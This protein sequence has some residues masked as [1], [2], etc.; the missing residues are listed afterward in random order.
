MQREQKERMTCIYFYWTYTFPRNDFSRLN[1]MLSILKHINV[2][3]QFVFRC[4]NVFSPISW[5]FDG[6]I[7]FY[8]LNLE[9]RISA[10]SCQISKKNVRIPFEA[11][12]WWGG[13]KL[14]QDFFFHVR[15]VYALCINSKKWFD[16]HK[17]DKEINK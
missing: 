7:N 5:L 13:G 15:Y 8:Y 1:K 3:K 12:K 11:Y 16:T 9:F 14:F 10:F 4:Q 6:F 17:I 2:Q